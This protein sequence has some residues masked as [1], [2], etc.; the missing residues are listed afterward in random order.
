MYHAHGVI[1]S[2]R[3]E[4]LAHRLAEFT[5]RLALRST[6]PSQ[7][8]AGEAFRFGEWHVDDWA[9]SIENVL[10]AVLVSVYQND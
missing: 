4:T 1:V 7:D 9:E 5:Q 3:I 2:H 6:L 8:G 10:E